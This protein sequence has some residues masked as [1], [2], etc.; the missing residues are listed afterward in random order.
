MWSRIA[1]TGH[2]VFDTNNFRS[3]I[4]R[5]RRPAIRGLR[6]RTD[7]PVRRTTVA[8]RTLQ[9]AWLA[10][11]SYGPCKGAVCKTAASMTAGM[12]QAASG[13]SGPRPVPNARRNA[14]CCE[15]RRK[16]DGVCMRS[17]EPSPMNGAATRPMLP[18]PQSRCVS[19][20]T[21]FAAGFKSA[22][23][24]RPC[25]GRSARRDRDG[26]ASAGEECVRVRARHH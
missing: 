2:I 4:P 19:A 10:V 9:A 23:P 3:P 1:I 25:T 17:V 7:R 20:V 22:P 18:M 6:T 5:G 13:T 12:P 26:N 24:A 15:G 8:R 21:S 14:L 11:Q 16:S